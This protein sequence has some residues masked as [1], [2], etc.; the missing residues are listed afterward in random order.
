M[1][2]KIKEII[3]KINIFKNIKV[4]NNI[5]LRIKLF[6]MSLLP[7][8]ILGSVTLGTFSTT[9]ISSSVS[10]TEEDLYAITAT[11][12]SAYEQN[13]GKYFYAS[14]GNLWKGSYNISLSKIMLEDIKERTTDDVTIIR[15]DEEAKEDP[16]KEIVASTAVDEETGEYLEYSL[17]EGLKEKIAS[18]S[19]IFA[20]GLTVDG[21]QQYF[22]A[23]PLI[24]DQTED[25][26]IGAIITSVSK[27]K[28]LSVVY[29][30][31]ER[32]IMIAVVMLLNGYTIIYSLANVC[33]N[34]F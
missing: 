21:V 18:G 20:D 12:L 19:S 8:I 15:F 10:Q 5:K 23:M 33:L 1:P 34:M 27:N 7:L 30:V 3:N 13:S 22:Y 25:E 17:D 31:M 6:L 4:F 26:V 9:Y 2:I 11:L 16:T 24:Q 28:K 29:D 32:L 14:N